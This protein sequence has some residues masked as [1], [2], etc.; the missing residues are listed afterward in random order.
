ML[1]KISG[2]RFPRLSC[3]KEE[4]QV[5]VLRTLQIFN[6][7]LSQWPAL[8]TSS[9]T[10]V[11][12]SATGNSDSSPF[13]FLC[14]SVQTWVIC[15]ECSCVAAESLQPNTRVCSWTRSH[16][17]LMNFALMP[18][19]F[20]LLHLGSV[21]W[22]VHRCLTLVSYTLPFSDFSKPCVTKGLL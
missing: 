8:N 16:A 9:W 7:E 6:L 12:I 20:Y 18:F 11:E 4:T 3:V 21:C 14:C 19:T 22:G 1:P 5:V 17:G 13:L 15:Q 10:P 2:L